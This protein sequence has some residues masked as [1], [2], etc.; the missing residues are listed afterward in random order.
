[1]FD[2]IRLVAWLTA[3]GLV[4]QFIL[5]GDISYKGKH[6]AK[7]TV[8]SFGDDFSHFLKNIKMFD[9]ENKSI[10]FIEIQIYYEMKRGNNHFI[11]VIIWRYETKTPNSAK[12]GGRVRL[13]WL[14]FDI[15][16]G[17]QKM[18]KFRHIKVWS[19]GEESK[20]SL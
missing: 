10:S 1:M 20:Y 4:I 13:E 7:L 12:S 6:L 19:P 11:C 3:W 9:F 5:C 15:S 2:F 17:F 18:H 8:S 14:S 16:S